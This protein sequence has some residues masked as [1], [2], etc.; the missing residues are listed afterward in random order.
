MV[1]LQNSLLSDILI[2]YLLLPYQKISSTRARPLSIL[3]TVLSSTIVPG[4]WFVWIFLEWVDH[5]YFNNIP[6][7]FP[8][9]CT[10]FYVLKL[11]KKKWTSNI[12]DLRRFHKVKVYLLLNKGFKILSRFL[13]LWMRFLYL[14]HF[15]EL[16]NKIKI[17]C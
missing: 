3:Y 5:L 14:H 4:A 2:W 12:G 9:A 10:D 17:I 8:P 16:Q 6:Y 11:L 13:W 7:L 15:H 1:L